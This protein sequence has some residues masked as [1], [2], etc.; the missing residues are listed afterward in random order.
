ML[1]WCLARLRCRPVSLKVLSLQGPSIVEEWTDF[2]TLRFKTAIE[3]RNWRKTEAQDFA[4]VLAR[5]LDVAKDSGLDIANEPLAEIPLRELAALWYADQHPKYH[6][7]TDYYR[8]SSASLDGIPRGMW[9]EA[10]KCSKLTNRPKST[11]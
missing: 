4:K 2:G 9:V 8:E 5:T 7:T 6:E 10:K 3:N 1:P 11:D